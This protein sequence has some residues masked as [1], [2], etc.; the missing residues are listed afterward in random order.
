MNNQNTE[1]AGE[2]NRKQRNQDARIAVCCFNPNQSHRYALALQKAGFSFARE[3]TPQTLATSST[4]PGVIDLLICDADNHSAMHD[5]LNWIS[6]LE[7]TQPRIGAIAVT[8]YEDPRWI[9]KCVRR[10]AINC[11]LSCEEDSSLVEI[12]S[13][14]IDRHK[15]GID[16]LKTIDERRRATVSARLREAISAEAI[17]VHFQPIV[18]CGN[19]NCTRVEALARWTD[20][21]LGSVSPTE[22]IAAAEEE[23]FVSPLGQLVLRKSL[24]ALA[25]LRTRNHNPLF[26]VNVSRQQFDNPNLVKEYLA[27]VEA[28]GESPS[29]I[30]IEVTE[31]AKFENHILALSLMQDFIDAGFQLAVDDF[32]TGESSF[33]QMSHVQYSELKIDRSLVSCIFEPSG[34][35]IM[36]SVISMAKSLNMHLVAEGVEDKQTADLLESLEIDFCQGYFFA[37]PLALM[38]LVSFLDENNEINAHPSNAR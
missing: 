30:I 5:P 10:G 11:H 24:L 14:C 18:N 9:V 38:E 2:A 3:V 4:P 33:L 22:F 15:R 8:S 26:S 16:N 17:D 28:H 32:G 36:R 1:P 23:G 35:S 19:W 34:L 12:S 27:I 7:K 20:K 6:L 21:S 25:D 37:R 13:E 31:T 29:Q